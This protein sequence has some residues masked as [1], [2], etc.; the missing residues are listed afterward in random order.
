MTLEDLGN[1]G[2][3]IGGVG[4]V[5]TLVYLAVQIRAN[6]TQ[7]REN[8]RL[9][10]MQAHRDVGERSADVLFEVAKEPELYRIWSTGFDFHGERPPDVV[11]RYGMIL[12]KVFISFE[13]AERFAEYDE[14][15]R[16]RVER[17][18]ANFLGTPSVRDWWSRQRRSYSESFRARIDARIREM[19]DGGAG[20]L[21]PPAASRGT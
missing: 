6:T 1:I 17:L 15:V 13:D 3:F 5:V 4:V 21:P 16:Q 14:S 18:E 19:D 8:S 7:V 11:E 9:I 10:G 20:P 2:D 12:H